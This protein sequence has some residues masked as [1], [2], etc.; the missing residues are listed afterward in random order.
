[1]TYLSI[2]YIYFWKLAVLF[3]SLLA[4]SFLKLKDDMPKLLVTYL[5]KATKK[6]FF[7]YD[8]V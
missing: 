1:M 7:T 6:L 2:Q 4:L 3:L 5:T 8:T